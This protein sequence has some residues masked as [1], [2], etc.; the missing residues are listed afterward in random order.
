MGICKGGIRVNVSCVV[1]LLYKQSIEHWNQINRSRLE[2][3]GERTAGRVLTLG[4][5][6]TYLLHGAES[7]L[8]S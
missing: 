7:F 4:C 3:I 6:F 1:A 2:H 8:R 5:L